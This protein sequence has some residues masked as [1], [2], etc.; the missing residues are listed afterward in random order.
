MSSA[1]SNHKLIFVMG[2]PGAGKDT[3]ADLLAS[4]FEMTR[5]RTSK[6]LE[7]KFNNAKPE[8]SNY[9][10]LI[11]EKNKWHSGLLN[12]PNWVASIIN[13]K[14]T[15]LASKNQGIIFSGSPRILEEFKDEQPVFEKLFKKEEIIAF[16]IKLSEE[17]SI[18]RNSKRLICEKSEHPIDPELVK[19][20]V[21]LCPQDGSKIVSRGDLD[22]PETIKVRL[23]EFLDRTMP[24]IDYLK[25]IGIRVVEINGDQPI[26]KVHLDI[27]QY[28]Y[29]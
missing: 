27:V 17:E 5:V 11:E 29:D 9:L 15:D 19:Q 21:Q 7:E 3:Q 14:I 22:N 6:L 28:L 18:K 4:Q 20:N 23:E 24:V 12:S 13:E 26:D 2:P 16:Y 10:K 8:D 25:Q 1:I